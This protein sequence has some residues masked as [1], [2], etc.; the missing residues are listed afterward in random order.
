ML[1]QA[2]RVGLVG[3]DGVQTLDLAGPLDAF[4]SAS[5]LHPQAYETLVLT[6][7]GQPFASETGLRM[8]P[9]AALKDAGPLD[10]LILAGGAGLRRPGVAQAMAQALRE[11]APRLRRLVSICTGLYGL[12]PS[13][14][15]DGRRVTTHWNFAA[16]IAAR[17]PALRM[18]PDAIF[19]K[20]GPIYTSAGITAAIDMALALIE[21]DYGAA[22]ALAVARDLV[23]Y[24][25]R[26]GGQRQ[27]SQPLRLQVRAGDRFADLAV[28]M[29]EHLDQDLSVEA[30]AARVGLSPRQF[31]R[32]F[33]EAFGASPG[34]Q[35][36]SLRLDAAR[37]LL[38][39]ASASVESIAAAVGFKSDDV[40]RR[41][42]DRGFGLSPTEYR[43]R[44]SPTLRT[45]AHAETA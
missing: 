16:D 10:T 2:I 21:E 18:E 36:E 33:S 6:L 3:Y 11:R 32:R 29:A 5:V 19:I 14:L 39:N 43:R 38:I 1:R 9:D 44:F 26:S 25:K 13:G 42:F 30:L 28:W 31:A 22:L 20:D 24:L 34:Q 4:G 35:V 17:F 12:A 8:A 41:A 7:D 40:F 37:E 45:P 23:V 27:Y 15:A